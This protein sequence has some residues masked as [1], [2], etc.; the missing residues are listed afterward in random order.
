MTFLSPLSKEGYLYQLRWQ[1]RALLENP[2]PF[3]ADEEECE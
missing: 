3:W 2:R 1:L